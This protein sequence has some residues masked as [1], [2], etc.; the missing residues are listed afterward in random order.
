MTTDLFSIIKER[1]GWSDDYIADINTPT[2]EHLRDIDT[3][4]GELKKI[5]DSGDRLV[6][7]PDIDMDGITAGTIGYAGFRELG[8]NVA[9]HIPH[10]ENGHGFK[11]S[12]AAEIES[13]YPDTKAVITCDTGIDSYEGIDAAHE[14]GWKIF[15]TDHHEEE[16]R[17]GVR[18]G[19]DVVVDPCRIDD[20]YPLKGICGAHVLYMVLTRY[21]ELYAPIKSRDIKLLAVFAGVGT[22]ADMMPVLKENRQVVADSVSIMR[23]LYLSKKELLDGKRVDD[24]ILMQILNQGQHS[25]E[26]V[27]AFRGMATLLFDFTNIG[28]IRDVDDI[29]EGFHGFYV[30][31]SFNSIRRI[32]NTEIDGI[33]VTL[34][35]AFGVFFHRDMQSMLES[36]KRIR[37]VSERR[38]ELVKDYTAMIDSMPQPF[39]PFIYLTDAPGG[40][41]GLLANQIRMNTELPVLVVRNAARYEG[42]IELRGSGRAPAWYDL[43]DSITGA[44]FWA[45][46]H[47]HA[48]GVGIGDLDDAQRLFNHLNVSVRETIQELNAEGVGTTPLADLRL[49]ETGDC[50]DTLDDLDAIVNT[51]EAIEEYAPFGVQFPRPVVEFVV[52]LEECNIRLMGSDK[53]HLSVTTP[54][55]IKMIW[56]NKHN[57]QKDLLRHIEDGEPMVAFSGRIAVNEFRGE[58]LPQLIVD[59]YRQV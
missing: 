26:Y 27:A 44:D 40:M 11:A 5:H 1:R 47:Q 57:M 41:L 23:L 8:F 34:A 2:S 18:I 21:S 22:V 37:A 14:R 36:M 33:N 13:L 3:L 45:A 4:C 35:D 48:F 25:P 50:D 20:E 30:A 17:G 24:T 56:W 55:G 39:A 54:N 28:K 16:P 42:E 32:P 6:V 38:K 7:Y 52:N 10:A 43:K 51:A 31:P 58:R 12:D 49:G 9:L 46:G 19:A 29:N 15:V 53:T 59:A